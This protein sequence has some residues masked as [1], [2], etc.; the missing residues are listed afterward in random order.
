MNITELI[1]ELQ[2]C[3]EKKGDLPVYAYDLDTMFE[4]EIE[5]RNVY[6]LDDEYYLDENDKGERVLKYPKRLTVSPC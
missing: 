3:K 6:L 5:K 2:K 4:R 1:N